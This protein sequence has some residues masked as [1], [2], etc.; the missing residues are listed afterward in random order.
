MKPLSPPPSRSSRRIGLTLACLASGLGAVAGE[1]AEQVRPILKDCC[2]GC[3]S[4]QKK[5]GDLDLEGFVDEASV[6]RRP[7]VWEQVLEQVESG[8]MPPKKEP[9]LA[10]AAK[11]TLTSWVRRE[12]D[13]LALASAGDPG[14][15]VL[16]RLS[17][18]E[19]AHTLRD[20]TGVASLDPG[21][22]FPVDGAAGEGFTNVGAALVMSPALLTKYLDAA[23]EV[24][25]HLVPLP[26]GVRFSPGVSSRD[27][28]DEALARI[29]AFYARY[30]VS[31]AASDVAATADGVE[32]D[33]GTGGGRI[34]LGAYFAA[35]RGQGDRAALS[36]R[37]L[38]ALRAAMESAAPSPLVA[39]LQRKHRAGT[40]AEADVAP[41]QSALWRFSTVGQMGRKEG[42]KAWQ[43][44]VESVVGS[45]EFREK[46]AGDATVRLVAGDAGDGATGDQVVW[47]RPRL[48]VPGRP[49]IPLD[50]LPGLLSHLESGMS[51]HAALTPQVLRAAEIGRA[52]V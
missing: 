19:Y 33:K 15:V 52:H 14:P 30:T 26:D 34:P 49:E 48:K 12:L 9:A 38:A 51:R 1:F 10:P 45:V 35:L 13:A 36:P 3:H 32:L 7:K 21:R 31:S 29:R 6:R 42:A 5:K 2:L 17:N 43:E 27:W 39:P 24:G 8:E 11:A 23:K 37:Y 40:L 46:L 16:R 47:E 18:A 25:E 20:L 4:A 44:P 22:E 41:W 28:T 50:D